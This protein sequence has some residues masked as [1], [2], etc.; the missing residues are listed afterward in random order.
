MNDLNT[1][2]NLGKIL[3]QQLESVG[4]STGT[5]LKA[6]GAEEAFARLATIDDS[7]CINMLYALEGAIQGIRWHQLSPERKKELLDYFHFC[8]KQIN[9]K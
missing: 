5:Q 2:P 9:P 4:I 7:A 1:L 6:T 8:K 3:A